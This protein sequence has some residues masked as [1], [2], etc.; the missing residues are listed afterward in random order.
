MAAGPPGKTVDIVRRLGA[1]S[2]IYAATNLLQKGT[3]FLL[4]PLYTLYLDPSAYGVLAIV[5]A[6][7]GLLGIAF[8]LGLT[9][10]VT[11]FYIEYQD[12]PQRLAEF[13][14]T[15]LAFVMLL[16]AVVGG[17]LF[18]VG[19]VLL[20]PIIGAVPFWPYVALG[21]A[22]TFFQPFFTTFLA[23][24]QTRNQAAHYALVSLAHFALTTLLTIA[25][26]VLLGWGVVGALSATLAAA[27]V[28]FVVSLW[29]LRA[30]LKLCLRWGHLRRGLSY[31]LPQVPHSLASQTSAITDR[32]ILN[33]QLGT[34]AAGLYSVGAMVALIVEVAAQSV[35]RAY[36]PLS[37]AALK[38]G[39]PHDLEQLRALGALVV[40]G[41]CLLGAAIGSFGREIV[42]LLAAPAFAGAAPVIPVLV[43]AGVA[44]AVYYL[45]VNVLFF[46][47]AAIRLLPLGTISAAVLNVALALLLVPRFGL[48]GAASS[49]LLAQTLG[50]LL[51][52]WIGRRFDPV[53]WDYGRY[54][55]AFAASLAWTLCLTTLEAGHPAA[56]T[57]L[58][59]AG[60]A[61]LAALLGALFWSRPLILAEA[62]LRLLARRPADAAALFDAPRRAT[63]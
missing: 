29:L 24:L 31:S 5:T 40:A 62:A 23:V 35:N 47:F 36:V 1:N 18:L 30:D 8:T 43:F 13:W 48:L 58:K 11:R 53:R 46:D 22:A 33:G 57:A 10:A 9:G 55:L 15:V 61:L 60:L 45:L 20:R 44:S 4:M 39:Q 17:A 37:M 12:D 49:T 28:F 50:T 26:V 34:A 42:W 27:A 56:T 21:V 52:A 63:P 2:A 32:I 3:A 38:S 6:V 14:G 19:D 25:L 51:I 54:A 59:V 16:S 7:N 41:F